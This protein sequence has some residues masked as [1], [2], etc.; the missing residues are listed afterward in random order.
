MSIVL[1]YS[2]VELRSKIL[3]LDNKNEKMHLSFWIVLAYSY[4]CK[5]SVI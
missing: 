3:T 2:I 4:L 5:K 1:A